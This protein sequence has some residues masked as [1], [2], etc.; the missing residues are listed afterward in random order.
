ML[1]GYRRHGCAKPQRSSPATQPGQNHKLPQKHCGSFCDS[2]CLQQWEDNISELLSCTHTQTQL[3]SLDPDIHTLY[4]HIVMVSNI[5]L[6]AILKVN[7][8]YMS[9][10]LC[11][12]SACSIQGQKDECKTCLCIQK[13]FL[14]SILLFFSFQWPLQIVARWQQC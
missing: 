9:F 6:P 12:F 2:Y 8:S 10:N 5:Y 14:V 7:M 11:F 4:R 3:W 13:V 1:W